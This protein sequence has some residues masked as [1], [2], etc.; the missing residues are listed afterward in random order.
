[1]LAIKKLDRHAAVDLFLPL[2]NS[3][4]SKGELHCI[5]NLRR[6]IGLPPNL[7]LLDNDKL[8]KITSRHRDPQ[9]ECVWPVTLHRASKIDVLLKSFNYTGEL[10]MEGG[11]KLVFV[12]RSTASTKKEI[13]FIARLIDIKSILHHR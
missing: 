13:H 7:E 5:F 2:G 12:G 3:K 8:M 6:D 1:M 9:A 11:N 4:G 10:S